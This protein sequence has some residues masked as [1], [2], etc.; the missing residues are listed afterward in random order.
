[1]PSVDCGFSD[2]PQVNG[3]ALLT[4]YGPTLKVNVGF[5]PIF[6]KTSTELPVAAVLNLDALVDTGA[7]E[8]CI[9][10][11]LAARINLP[12]VD[13]QPLSGSN[14][15]HTTNI[16]EAQV[17]VPALGKTIV[18]RFAGVELIAGGQVHH[19]LI[20]RTFLQ[21]VRITYDGTTGSVVI[22]TD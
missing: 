21:N 6:N 7:A 9:D 14:G 2:T 20:G 12:V 18:G 17:F 10:N 13:R 11:L 8:S 4:A 22:S 19:V 3:G 15:A 1:M 5:D 16:Y